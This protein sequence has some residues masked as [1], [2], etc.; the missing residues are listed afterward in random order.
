LPEDGGN[1]PA[2]SED[3]PMKIPA[4]LVQATGSAS[5]PWLLI[6]TVLVA[7]AAGAAIAF[8]NGGAIIDHETPVERGFVAVQ[9]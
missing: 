6:G 5:I 9:K 8:I 7:V 1:A 2:V 4:T 3:V